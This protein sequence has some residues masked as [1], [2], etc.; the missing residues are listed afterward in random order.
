MI[1]LVFCNSISDHSFSKSF[2]AKILRVAVKELK[3]KGRISVSVNLVGETKMRELNKK[4]RRKD[5]PTD[6]LSFPLGDG[7]GDIFVCLS[8]AKKEAKR[9]NVSIEKKL[10]QLTVHGFLHL[11]GYDHENSKA[12]AREMFKIEKIILNN[13]KLKD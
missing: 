10:T 1:D 3:L 8:I 13:L 11:L 9:E 5:E 12:S 6:V 2:F 7:S 4:Y